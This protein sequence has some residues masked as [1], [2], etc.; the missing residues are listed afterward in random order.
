ML[1]RSTKN[2][3][4]VKIEKE[5]TGRLG[6]FYGNFDFTVQVSGETVPRTFSLS[7]GKSEILDNIPKE[8]VLTL[9][10]DAKGH[11]ITVKVD[12]GTISVEDDGS[13][14]IGLANY[15]ADGE[16]FITIEVNNHYDGQIDTGISLDSLPYIGILAVVTIG[17]GAGFVRKRNNDQED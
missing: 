16:G 5:V 1:F 13:Y 9:S 2:T 11:D 3:V 14:I 15:E 8:A 17:L 12:G 7:D 4:N 6:D 10:E